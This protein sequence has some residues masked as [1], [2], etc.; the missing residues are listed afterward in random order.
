MI[1]KN[2]FQHRMEKF[3][4]KFNIIA[5][6]PFSVLD[7]LQSFN[8]AVVRITLKSEAEAYFFFMDGALLFRGVRKRKNVTDFV[9]VKDDK[10]EL[11]KTSY[12][13]ED[14]QIVFAHCGV[15]T[16]LGQWVKYFSEINHTDSYRLINIAVNNVAK[17]FGL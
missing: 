8:T 6:A 2:L 14:T 3:T 4:P 10:I 16:L 7:L 17:E 9:F 11:V 12:S 1:V 13:F 15:A 5:M